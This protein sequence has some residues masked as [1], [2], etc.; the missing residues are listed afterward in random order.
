MIARAW[1]TRLVGFSLAIATG[2]S[3]SPGEDAVRP[4]F[5]FD[6]P[7]AVDAL[8]AL[9]NLPLEV[10]APPEAAAGGPKTERNLPAISCANRASISP[11]DA[12]I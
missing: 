10:A 11:L 9:N 7:A 1:L 4:L 3:I 8:V 5:S 12:H 2:V 6:E